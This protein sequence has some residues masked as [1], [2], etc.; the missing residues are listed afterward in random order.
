M[1]AKHISTK[2]IAPYPQISN[3]TFQYRTLDLS[4]QSL[5]KNM[6]EN[7]GVINEGEGKTVNEANEWQTVNEDIGRDQ[8]TKPKKDRSTKLFGKRS[9]VAMKEQSTR[10]L[11]KR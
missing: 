4:N 5:I 11:I 3:A 2:H 9:T 1:P 6:I 10:P 7:I 8:H